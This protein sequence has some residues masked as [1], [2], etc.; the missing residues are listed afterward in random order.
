MTDVMKL[1]YKVVFELSNL[2]NLR[3]HLITVSQNRNI[4]SANEMNDLR[5][6][7]TKL[8]KEIIRRSLGQDLEKPKRKSRKASVVCDGPA[9]S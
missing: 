1:N 3:N 5:A 7:V 6:L 8:D 9:Q 2:A 4:S